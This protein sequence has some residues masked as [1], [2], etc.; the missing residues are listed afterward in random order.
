MTTVT[1]EVE[2]VG[3]LQIA[4]YTAEAATNCRVLLER[5]PLTLTLCHSMFSGQALEGRIPELRAAPENPRW[6]GLQPGTLGVEF[7]IPGQPETGLGLVLVYGRS[8]QYRTPYAPLGAPLHVIGQV[9][10]NLAALLAAGQRY[11]EE[12]EGRVLIAAERGAD[13]ACVPD[14]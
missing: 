12:G 2:R 14:F 11:Q 10:G 13:G 1:L 7:P 4:L 8:F 5:L 6:Y 9:E 3:R